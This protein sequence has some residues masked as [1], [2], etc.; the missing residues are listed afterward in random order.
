MAIF[1]SYVSLPEGTPQCMADIDP[2][3]NYMRRVSVTRLRDE[4][5]KRSSFISLDASQ[6]TKQIA[7]W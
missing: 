7:L 4:R 2:F 6:R 5:L 1:N 3:R